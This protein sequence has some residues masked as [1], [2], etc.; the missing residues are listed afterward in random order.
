MRRPTRRSGRRPALSPE[1][2]AATRTLF[3]GSGSFGVPILDA[4]VDDPEV[5]V[6]GVVTVGR[7]A[8]DRGHR[9]AQT[10][11]A[12]RAAERGL[13]VLA[14]P[15][16]RDAATVDRIVGM[17]ATL[18]VLADY[19]R[20]V[21][22]TLIA[23]FERGI[24]NVH[25]SLLPRWRGASPIAATIAAGDEQAGV[26]IIAMDAGIDSGPIVAAAGW[27][28]LGDE[29]AP[30]LRAIA[31]ERGA[32]LLRRTLG[33]W[34]RGEIEAR[35]QSEELA[36]MTRPLTREAGRLDPTCPAA[37]LERLVRALRPWPACHLE[38]AV[39]RLIVWVARTSDSRPSDRPGTIVGDAGTLALATT[40]GRLVLDE[41]QPA[42]GRRMSGPELLRGRGRSLPGTEVIAARTMVEPWMNAG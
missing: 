39:G 23:R 2:P 36:T 3:F 34:T 9:E 20:I 32:T 6:V 40:T 10:P 14:P 25:P 41:V 12:L 17:K 38:T 5:L 33:P 13:T 29:D 11:V 16:L 24:L 21:P 1:P 7:P 31:A 30:S 26:S 35:P 27:A 22:Q 8:D 42:G 37:S 19:G 18:G 15:S 4:L 28:M